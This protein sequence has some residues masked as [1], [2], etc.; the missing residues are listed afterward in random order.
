[1]TLVFYRIG[2]GF[3]L[4]SE[5]F[6]NIVAAAFQMSSFTHVEVA[7]GK[8]TTRLAAHQ[9]PSHPATQPANKTN[10]FPG[11]WHLTRRAVYCLAQETRLVRWG[12]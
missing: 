11:V 2:N 5:P 9:P 6:L 1:M 3:A 10:F 4:F 12:R 7:I 8:P